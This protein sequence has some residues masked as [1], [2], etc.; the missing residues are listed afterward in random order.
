[1]ILEKGKKE[2]IEEARARA[3]DKGHSPGRGGRARETQRQL[4]I[5]GPR[6]R[7]PQRQGRFTKRPCPMLSSWTTNIF[8]CLRRLRNGGPGGVAGLC[9]ASRKET[10]VQMSNLKHIYDKANVD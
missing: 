1:M 5:S 8:V 6:Q 7:S 4:D 10:H 2:D 3:R 9:K